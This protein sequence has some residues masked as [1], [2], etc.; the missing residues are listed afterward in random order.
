MPRTDDEKIADDALA[1]FRTGAEELLARKQ[2]ASDWLSYSEAIDLIRSRLGIPHG[3]ATAELK[4]ARNSGEIA[5]WPQSAPP[6]F[7]PYKSTPRIVDE[8]FGR[9]EEIDLYFKKIDLEYW[10]DR[11]RPKAKGGKT[12]P[13]RPQI[14]RDRAEEAVKA[15]WP[16][17]VPEPT[18]LPND[19]LCRKVDGWLRAD[20]KTRGIEF[21]APSNDTIL[22]AAGRK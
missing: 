15:L 19:L 6:L 12:T 18:L 5:Y 22:R 8:A 21:V 2:K 7:D 10:L 1:E 3:P 14:K 13:R 4:R 11:E 17:R 20:C 16:N 9:R